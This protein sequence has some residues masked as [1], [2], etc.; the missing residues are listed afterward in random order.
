MPINIFIRDI[1]G[2]REFLIFKNEDEF[3]EF[4]WNNYDDDN[5]QILLVTYGSHCIYSALNSNQIYF[6]DLIGFFA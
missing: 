4:N 6:E 2:K 5:Y 3:N 1:N